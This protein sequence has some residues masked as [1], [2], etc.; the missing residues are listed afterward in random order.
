MSVLDKSRFAQAVK[1]TRHDRSTLDESGNPTKYQAKP[2]KP[3]QIVLDTERYIY[4]SRLPVEAGTEIPRMVD[5][6]P[7]WTLMEEYASRTLTHKPRDTPTRGGTHSPS[8]NQDLDRALQVACDMGRWDIA[9]M[10]VVR[11]WDLGAVK[12]DSIVWETFPHTSQMSVISDGRLFTPAGLSKV[13]IEN[14]WAWQG[15]YHCPGSV[16]WVDWDEYA[17]FMNGIRNPFKLAGVPDMEERIS[18][19]E[20]PV[21]QVPGALNPSDLAGRAWWWGQGVAYLANHLGTVLPYWFVTSEDGS[22]GR[23]GE[24]AW[25]PSVR[26]SLSRKMNLPVLIA[27]KSNVFS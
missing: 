24:L 25:G 3:N 15:G 7:G 21:G 16:L 11:H 20:R 12:P 10:M 17:A 26:N 22:T 2:W 18:S 27:R 13:V 19:E 4:V 23:V 9:F 6:N 8:R 1:V 5:V 14:W